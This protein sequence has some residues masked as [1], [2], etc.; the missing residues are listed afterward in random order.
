MLYGDI[1]ACVYNSCDKVQ[2]LERLHK[3]NTE[4]KTR[5]VSMPYKTYVMQNILQV[6]ATYITTPTTGY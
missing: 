2:E 6:T 5:Q 1:F 4:L 3:L